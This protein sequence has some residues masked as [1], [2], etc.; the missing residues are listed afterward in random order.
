MMI[1]CTYLHL[2]NTIVNVQIFKIKKVD[3]ILTISSS[4]SRKTKKGTKNHY[5]NFVHLNLLADI[6]VSVQR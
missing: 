4:G 5:P 6:N 3:K 1:F 2:L